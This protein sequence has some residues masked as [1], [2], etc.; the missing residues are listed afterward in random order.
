[1]EPTQLLQE[2]RQ[3]A[4]TWRVEVKNLRETQQYLERVAR[5]MA[6][7]PLYRAI[8]RAT[9]MIER[10]AKKMAPVHTGR[11]RASI[12][13]RV[14]VLPMAGGMQTRGIVSTNVAYASTMEHGGPL[15]SSFVEIMRWVHLKRLAGAY[16]PKTKRRMGGA[17]T[18][19]SEDRAV[20]A[21]IYRS[22]QANGVKAHPFMLPAL[23]KNIGAIWR[24]MGDFVA[25][26]ISR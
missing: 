3:Q 23:E 13:P 21:R 19:I 6:G 25:E 4:A 1:M 2:W 7:D 11:L 26:V 15:T 10:E 16:S 20:T 9:T 22:M 12:T 5:D 14:E 18:Q 17:A 24:L 8:V